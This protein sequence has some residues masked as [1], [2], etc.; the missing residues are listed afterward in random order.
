[1]PGDNHALTRQ[2][3]CRSGAKIST[4]CRFSRIP[5]IGECREGVMPR[6]LRRRRGASG[7]RVPGS[8]PSGND[9]C[10]VHLWHTTAERVTSGPWETPNPELPLFAKQRTKMPIW[11]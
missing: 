3:N 5:R 7:V 8:A 11:F 10:Q 2:E 9:P 6:V 1:V 4:L